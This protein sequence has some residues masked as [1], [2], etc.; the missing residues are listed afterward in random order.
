M[1]QADARIVR[2]EKY[3]KREQDLVWLDVVDVL[4]E[5]HQSGGMLK[6]KTSGAS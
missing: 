2:N 4:V 3:K 5:Q 1:E 6:F